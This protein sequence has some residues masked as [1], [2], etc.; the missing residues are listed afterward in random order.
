MHTERILCDH[1]VEINMMPLASRRL[2]AT[3]QKQEGGMGQ[4]L[5]HLHEKP[6]LP[7][8]DLRLLAPKLRR[9]VSP[10]YSRLPVVLG[11]SSPSE[12]RAWSCVWRAPPWSTGARCPWPPHLLGSFPLCCTLSLVLWDDGRN[13]ATYPVTEPLPYHQVSFP[14]FTALWTFLQPLQCILLSIS[15]SISKYNGVPQRS[16]PSAHALTPHMP[17]KAGG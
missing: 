1:E 16:G 14:A 4:V 8:T 10:V 11:C 2:L 15:L 9:C 3:P 5:S 6:T 7:T 17:N 12:L 13:R